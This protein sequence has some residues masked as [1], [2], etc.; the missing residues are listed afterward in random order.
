MRSTFSRIAVVALTL[1]LGLAAGA[2]NALTSTA[3]STISFGACT[4]GCNASFGGSVSPPF[5]AFSDWIN[6]TIPSSTSGNGAAYVFNT[7]QSG[8]NINFSAFDLYMGTGTLSNTC[9]GCGA[10][11]A[12]GPAGLASALTFIGVSPGAYTLNVA[13]SLVP[14]ATTGNYTGSV[15]ISSIGAVPEP[16]TYAMLLAGLGLVGFSARRRNENT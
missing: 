11:V 9:P 16:K 3:V 13:G 1:W 2:A 8:T 15:G 10:P 12:T 4:S 5:T 7:L 6:F 14:G